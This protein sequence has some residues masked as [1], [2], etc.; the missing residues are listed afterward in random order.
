MLR[1]KPPIFNTVGSIFPVEPSNISCLI[2]FLVSLAAIFAIV[3]HSP[4][5]HGVQQKFTFANTLGRPLMFTAFLEILPQ[6]AARY[7]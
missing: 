7:R 4:M 3:C 6:I 2:A 5:P 1:L